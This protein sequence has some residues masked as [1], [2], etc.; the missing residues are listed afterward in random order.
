MSGRSC[1]AS[2]SRFLPMKHHGHTTSETTSIVSGLAMEHT[3]VST[4]VGSDLLRRNQPLVDGARDQRV[5]R[6]ARAK[7]RKCDSGPKSRAL[8]ADC[9]RRVLEHARDAPRDHMRGHEIG[10]GECNQD[11][12]VLVAARDIA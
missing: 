7:R 4:K 10:L 11:G 2:S 9:K 12:A 3:L 8:A 1:S 6:V 5:D